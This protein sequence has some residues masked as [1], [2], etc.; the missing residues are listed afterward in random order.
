MNCIILICG[1]ILGYKQGYKIMK[2]VFV[3]FKI[4]APL[5]IILVFKNSLSN[6]L[7]KLLKQILLLIT[8]GPPE[9][10][11]VINIYTLF[12]FFHLKQ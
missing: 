7:S 6:F 4:A 3:S 2:E 5:P 12:N 9:R 10:E 8:E 11:V 1:K